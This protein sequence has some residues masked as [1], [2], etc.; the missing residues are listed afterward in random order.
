MWPASWIQ[1]P[2]VQ[3]QG[4]ILLLTRSWEKAGRPDVWSASFETDLWP[5]LMHVLLSLPHLQTD[6]YGVRGPSHDFL[7]SLCPLPRI[8]SD[9]FSPFLY[10][11][12][13]SS[14]GQLSS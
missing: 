8:D 2:R 11:G 3:G 12:L 6:G 13:H 14:L 5:S 1:E 7:G 9:Q 4:L 10:P